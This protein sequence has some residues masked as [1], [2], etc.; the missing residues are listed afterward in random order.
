MLGL[1][2]LSSINNSN[3]LAFHFVDFRNRSLE[4]KNC[5][6]LQREQIADVVVAVKAMSEE[7]TRKIL[8]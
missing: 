3:A 8:V 7:K 1:G 2:R 4:K 6:L 5:F